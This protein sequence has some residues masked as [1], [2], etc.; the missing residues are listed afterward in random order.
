MEARARERE[1]EA[2]EDSM[3][4]EAARVQQ[5]QEAAARAA[6]LQ[7]R[8]EDA[9]AE[10]LVSAAA[11]AAARA[12]AMVEAEAKAKET[13]DEHGWA[14]LLL[15]KRLQRS[16]AQV[17]KL[18]AQ[19]LHVPHSRSAAEWASLNAAAE[20]QASRREQL[21]IAAFIDSH[22]WR[23]TD[24]AIVLQQRGLLA[25]LFDSPEGTDM[26]MKRLGMLMG[27]MEQ[28][29]YGMAFALHLHFELQLTLPKVHGMMQAACKRFNKETN[30]YAAKVLY[31]NKHRKKHFIK[32]PRI[33][34]PVYKIQAAIEQIYT[35]LGTEIA[36][37]GRIAFRSLTVVV[38]ELLARD[39]GRY[40]MPAFTAFTRHN[41][42][43]VKL[44]VILQ[45]DGTGFGKQ[46]FNTL[47]ISNPY[48]PRSS[49]QLHILGLGN[50]NDSRAGTVGVFGPNLAEA[51]AMIRCEQEG[52]EYRCGDSGIDPDVYVCTDVA[53]L[54]HCEHLANSGWCCCGR[55]DALRK[56][57]RKPETYAEMDTLLAQC[58]S[59]TFI[60]RCVLSHNTVPG[61]S[62]PRPCTAIGCTFGHTAEMALA[63]QKAMYE[64][65][66]ALAKVDTKAG[67]AAFSKWRMKHAHTHSNVQPGRYGEPMLRHDMHKQLL[68]ALHMSK[69]NVPKTLFKYGVLNNSSDDARDAISAQLKVWKHPIDCNRKD[70]NRVREQKWFTGE[71]WGSLCAGTNGSPGGPVAIATLVLIVIDDLMER[72]VQ[73]GPGKVGDAESSGAVGGATSGGRGGGR[74]GRGGGRAGGRGGARG[75]RGRS[76]FMQRAD[77]TSAGCVNAVLA[78]DAAATLAGAE[79][80][81]YVPTAVEQ[82]ADAADLEMIRQLFGSRAQLV[83][84]ILL[85]FDAFFKWFY[86]LVESV[87]FGCEQEQKRARAFDNCRR[88]IDMMEIT[89][90]VTIH[91][92]K[93]FM[94]HGAIYKL[95]RDINLVGD[96]WAFGTDALEL[97][98]ADTKRTADRG[99]S[100]HLTTSAQGKKPAPQ[101]SVRQGPANLITTRGYG[102]TMALSTL[103]KLLAKRYLREGDGLF[104]V[105]ESRRRERLFGVTGSGR[106][107]SSRAASACM[108]LLGLDYDPRKDTC[109]KAFLRLLAARGLDGDSSEL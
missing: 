13:E 7:Q 37:D 95:S 41:C 93:S 69:L 29:D 86:P 85:S 74:G 54:R 105:P 42:P 97:L 19:Q 99:G 45:W 58:K 75:G 48:T 18:R 109:I 27:E 73:S 87:P 9:E 83:I 34:P 50:C 15:E 38:Q 100:K 63:E 46:Q 94:F 23:V 24:L 49:Q 64:E 89:E 8:V 35:R 52:H 25:P 51:N 26:Y 81:P 77:E 40:E 22:P 61:E 101:M 98:N 56:V 33:V 55:E 31:Y 39:C 78:E 104:S 70:N 62:R 6:E 11:A 4:A 21:S 10:A 20:R 76:A 68:D 44:P 72:G 79:E 12:E 36:Q 43:R 102:T 108:E 17:T 80:L 60:E 84:N 53:A 96:V 106:V 14:V 92:H 59:P 88:A 65:E 66:A 71:A 5:Q 90:R 32:V 47:V 3:K 67:K 103:R 1:R 30:R 57:P 28:R 82:A 107:S 16:Q 2:F 91:H